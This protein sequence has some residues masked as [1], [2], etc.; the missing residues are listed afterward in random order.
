MRGVSGIL[1]DIGGV[2]VG[3]DGVPSLAKLMQFDPLHDEI[4]RRWMA[5]PSVVRHETGQI[6]ADQFAIEVV[7]D[8]GSAFHWSRIRAMG[9]P[10]RI[11]AIYLSHEI[12]CLKPAPEA[13]H[14]ALDGMALPPGEVLFLDDGAANVDSARALGIQAHL[15]RGP[16]E[17]ESVLRA[18]GVL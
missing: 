12:G 8:L 2:L 1:F 5:C 7:Q 17:A 18:H 13:F 6:T 4:H 15:V 3:L 14:V 9:L 11:D 10:V 16:V